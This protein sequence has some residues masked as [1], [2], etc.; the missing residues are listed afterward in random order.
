MKRAK[1]L[2]VWPRRR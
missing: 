2:V 1:L